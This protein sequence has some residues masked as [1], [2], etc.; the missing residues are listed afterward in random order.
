M[1]VCVCVPAVEAVKAMGVLA[2][3]PVS[4]EDRL[5]VC[6]DAASSLLS[7]AAQIA[8]EVGLHRGGQGGLIITISGRAGGVGVWGW[9]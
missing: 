2:C 3:G 7:L 8:L 1:C 5:L 9:W 4:S 6:E